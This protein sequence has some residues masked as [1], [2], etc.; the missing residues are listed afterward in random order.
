MQNVYNFKLMAAMPTLSSAANL[1]FTIISTEKP[2]LISYCNLFYFVLKSNTSIVVIK[3]TFSYVNVFFYNH[4]YRNSIFRNIF[5]KSG[6]KHRNREYSL[7]D[8]KKI[9]SR[10]TFFGISSFQALAMFR[11]TLSVCG[12]LSGS[13]AML[14]QWRP[15]LALGSFRLRHRSCLRFY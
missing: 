12:C 13:A 9:N 8:L 4:I 6:I 10:R 1:E 14:H 2:L 11:R 7:L 5:M 3:K 15:R